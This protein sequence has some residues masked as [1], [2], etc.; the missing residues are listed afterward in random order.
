MNTP[1]EGT[2]LSVQKVVNPMEAF[3][4]DFYVQLANWG[5]FE[6]AEEYRL[7]FDT[8]YQNKMKKQLELE[9]QN[10]MNETEKKEKEIKELEIEKSLEV[11]TEVENDEVEVVEKKEPIKKVIKK[12]VVSKKK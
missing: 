5:W 3:V 6:R 4:Y 12:K 8:E 2:P 10:K 7:K 1:N 11:E 9:N